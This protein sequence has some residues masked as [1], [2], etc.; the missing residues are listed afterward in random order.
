V[1]DGSVT[2]ETSKGT[3]T[4]T[5]YDRVFRRRLDSYGAGRTP[6]YSKYTGGR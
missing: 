1:R 4:L 5:G 3:T 6:S 2:V